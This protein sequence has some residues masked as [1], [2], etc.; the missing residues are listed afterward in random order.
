[1]D[2]SVGGVR[3]ERSREWTG[4]LYK[5]R[6]KLRYLEST[7]NKH[8]LCSIWDV[9]ILIGSLLLI[10][11]SPPFAPP[12]FSVRPSA[13]A[14][15]EHSES[16]ERIGHPRKDH[17]CHFSFSF[18]S[19][20]LLPFVPFVPFVPFSSL[21]LL[22]PRLS[23]QACCTKYPPRHPCPVDGERS[24]T[25]PSSIPADGNSGRRP[26]QPVLSSALMHFP[27][28]ACLRASSS[29]E[30]DSVSAERSS[31]QEGEALASA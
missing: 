16:L 21:P 15:D 18:I 4:V 20:L 10:S 30:V 28:M 25:F 24:R 23:P 26:P 13:L 1:M 14:I 19:S 8:G 17:F 29:A 6:Y 31:F 12:R 5:Y 3:T 2:A 7:S 11:P 9:Q 27:A 22:P